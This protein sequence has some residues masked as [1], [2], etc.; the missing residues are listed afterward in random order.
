MGLFK[1]IK[2]SSDK[3]KMMK[4]LIKVCDVQYF[5]PEK[6]FNDNA[7][8]K[9][10]RESVQKDFYEYICKDEVLGAILKKHKISYDDFDEYLNQLLACGMGWS[11][12]RYIPVDVFSFSRELEYFLT[13]MENKE[14]FD[15]ICYNLNHN[16]F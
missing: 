14:D 12:G 5:D 9:E 13:A 7:P 6:G 15:M 3:T 4:K 8:S 10:E 1:S 2:R 11:H 16:Q